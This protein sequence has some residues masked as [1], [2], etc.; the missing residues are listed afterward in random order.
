M[1]QSNC[2]VAQSGG[3]TAAI[4]ASLAGVISGIK[5]SGKYDTCYGAIN[6]I[7][8]ILNERYLNLSQM[9]PDEI[10]LNRLKVTPAMYLGSCRH[11]L[12]DYKDDDSAY[13]FIFNQFAKLNI[14]AF[15]YIGGND[16]MDTIKKLSDYAQTVGSPIRFIGVP[17]TI[18][19]DL[20]GTD[21]TP[22]YGSAAKYIATVTKELVREGL[23]YEMQSVTV[24]EIMGRN[25]GWLTGA[26]VLAKSE[27]CE[28]P[29]LIYLPEVPFDVDV[30]L[31]KV[32]KLV[33]EKQSI[34]I[35]VSEGIKTA[36]GR[37]VCELSAH[38]DKTD[39]F[40]HVQLSGTGKY[41][42]DLIIEKLGCKSRAIEL[43]TLQRCAGHLTSR[44][45]ITEAYQVG[46]TAVKAAF[47][48]KTGQ[49]V[50]LKR[51]SQDPYI[52]TTDLYDVH[53]VANLEKKVPRFWITE[54]GDYVTAEMKNYIEPL[55]QAELT[56][57]MITGQ[58]RH[59]IIDDLP[60]IK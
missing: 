41:L 12:P 43:S 1:N 44:V 28:G 25:A 42:S 38:S 26:A 10:T 29:D 60:D 18:D 13:V 30:F 31:E 52:C 37:Y 4:N 59:I 32:K 6:G 53:K 8:G 47:E 27:D 54:E 50:I 49:M 46:G 56:P 17:K 24:F 35:A 9:I 20:E 39:S 3:P 2:M 15:F 33:A 40:G 21:H 51:V 57:I 34:V 48:G 58:P 36:D 11:K 14:K 19:N 22:G 45:D 5:K 23:I 55:I 7:L 16:S